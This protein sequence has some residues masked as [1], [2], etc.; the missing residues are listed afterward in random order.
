VGGIRRLA[1]HFKQMSYV[2]M[3]LLTRSYLFTHSFQHVS[4]ELNLPQD[5]SEFYP[6]TGHEGIE[7]KYTYS[8]TLS[9][10]P[11]LDGMGGQGHAPTA[12][13]L[14]KETRYTL[15]GKLG[16]SQGRSGR[17]RKMSSPTGLRSPDRSASN[18]SL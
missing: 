5:K 11:A 16:G 4:V 8:S 14:G 1:K 17:L 2:H 18:H 12:L 13:P 3:Q 7:G 10:T 9:L 15:Y 6:R